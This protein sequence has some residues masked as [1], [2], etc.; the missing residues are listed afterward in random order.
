[1]IIT[2]SFFLSLFLASF[3]MIAFSYKLL[4]GRSESFDQIEF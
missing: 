2:E 4:S 1:M 3:D